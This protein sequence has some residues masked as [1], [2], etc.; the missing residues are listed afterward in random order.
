MRNALQHTRIAEGVYGSNPGRTARACA[1]TDVGTGLRAIRRARRRLGAFVSIELA[2]VV[3]DRVSGL[4]LTM[5][6]AS[7]LP[8]DGIS[9]DD[10]EKRMIERRGQFLM[11]GYGFGMI[12]GTR[13]SA[14][15][16]R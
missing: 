3:P 7:P 12:Q 10:A 16:P 4:H 1:E 6:L 11:D 5:P 13:Q 9:A 15:Q 14:D 2:R 8:E